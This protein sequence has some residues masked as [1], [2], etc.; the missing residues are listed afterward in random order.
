[1]HSPSAMRETMF[2]VKCNAHMAK[3]VPTREMGMATSTIR[4][5]RHRRR[6]RNSTRDGGDDALHQVQAGLGEGGLMKV[7]ASLATVSRRPRREGGLQAGQLRLHR[8][9]RGHDVRVALLAHEDADGGMRVQA[10]RLGGIGVVQGHLRDLRQAH[11]SA[12]GVGT[13][14]FL[15]VLDVR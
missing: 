13:R 6:K 5:E 9:C 4:E 8:V 3:N 7:V 12:V 14:R 1:M 15:H 10:H 11:A 2:S